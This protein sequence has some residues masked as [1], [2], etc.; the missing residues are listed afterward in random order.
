MSDGIFESMITVSE[1]GGPAWHEKGTVFADKPLPTVAVARI[2][3]D[4]KIIKAPSQARIDDETVIDL[5]GQFT[6]LRAPAGTSTEYVSLGACGADYVPIQNLELAQLLNPLSEHWP[7]ETVG[8]LGKGETIFITL[9]SGDLDLDG[10]HV[11]KFFLITDSK[12]PKDGGLTFKRVDER[13]VCRNT[14]DF[15]LAEYGDQVDIRHTGDIQT[16]AATVV[17]LYGRLRAQDEAVDATLRLLRAT[18][19][20]QE[21]AK[22]IFKATFPAPKT[23]GALK[24]ARAAGGTDGISAKGSEWVNGTGKA[25]QNEVARMERYELGAFQLYERI[26][27]EYPKI[28]GTAWAAVN[29]VTELVDWGPSR[30]KDRGGRA[31]WGEGQVF[32]QRAVKKARAFTPAR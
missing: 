12:N 19:V 6:V 8:V 2:G 25:W 30:N 5:P 10:D 23:P 32:K 13:V 14:L 21:N 4:F 15:A 22:A 7:V 18:K 27:D 24:L 20:T 29:A 28:G 17:E 26:C 16:R 31:L 3:A 9:F 11:K 1:R